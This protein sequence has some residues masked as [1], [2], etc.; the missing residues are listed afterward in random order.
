MIQASKMLFELQTCFQSAKQVTDKML[1]RANNVRHIPV[2]SV[3]QCAK[4]HAN[5]S[6]KHVKH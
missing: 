5:S 1:I 6:L 4:Q 2:Y 3:E